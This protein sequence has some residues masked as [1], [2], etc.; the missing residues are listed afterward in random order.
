MGFEPF[1]DFESGC[2]EV[3]FPSG[4]DVPYP[5]VGNLPCLRRTSMEKSHYLDCK[6]GYS[7]GLA[8]ATVRSQRL[9]S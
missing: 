9:S 8:G 5:G 1:G 4:G 2:T 6:A 3:E 7:K